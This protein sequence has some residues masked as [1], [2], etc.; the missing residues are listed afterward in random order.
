M[1]SVLPMLLSLPKAFIR[2][3]GLIGL[4]AF[5]GSA[6]AGQHYGHHNK[7]SFCNQEV[8]R[9]A[10]RKGDIASYTEMVKAVTDQFKGRIIRVELE[11]TEEGFFYQLRLL[12]GDS[13]VV[14]VRLDAQTLQ[15]VQVA[16]KALENISRN[17]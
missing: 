8:A 14:E 7:G 6:L 16:G 5:S 9:M 17:P 15:V 4:L 3:W 2:G 10:V 1:K 11:D 12:E 13:Q